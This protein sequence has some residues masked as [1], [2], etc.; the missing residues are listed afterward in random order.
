[1]SRTV[2]IERLLAGY[3]D[4]S[5]DPAQVVGRAYERARS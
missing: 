2:G 4:G 5:S 1:L 3:R